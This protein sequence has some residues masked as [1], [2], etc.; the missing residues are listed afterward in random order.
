MAQI[1][2]SGDLILE[3]LKR[4]VLI[5]YFVQGLLHWRNN[6]TWLQLC[7]SILANY[8]FL[9]LQ[10][11]VR[12]IPSVVL[13]YLCFVSW[14]QT[15]IDLS[16]SLNRWQMSVYKPGAVQNVVL[17]GVDISALEAATCHTKNRPDIYQ[18]CSQSFKEH[19]IRACYASFLI[20]TAKLIRHFF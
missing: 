14:N 4:Q 7:L 17:C 2:A 10:T 18:S 11:R 5:S 19:K 8:Q 20:S 12:K 13:S 15:E 1:L 6:V 16:F 9:Y 3:V